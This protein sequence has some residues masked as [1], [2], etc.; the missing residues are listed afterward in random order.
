MK[1]RKFLPVIPPLVINDQ[2]PQL[3]MFMLTFII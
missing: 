1:K 3:Y 2:A